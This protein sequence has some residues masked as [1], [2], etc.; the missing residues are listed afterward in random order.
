EIVGDESLDHGRCDR[1]VV[2][3]IAVGQHIDVRL[4]V[5]EHAPHDVAFALLGLALHDGAGGARLGGGVVGGVV[6][7]YVDIGV[8]QRAAKGGHNVPDD[9]AFVVAGQQH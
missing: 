9:G 1:G 6:V 5:R 2:G 3:A 7:V 4:D 8:R